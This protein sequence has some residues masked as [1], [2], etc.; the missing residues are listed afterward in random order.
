MNLGEDR[1]DEARPGRIFLEQPPDEEPSEALVIQAHDRAGPVG[2]L[3][4]PPTPT[5][6]GSGSVCNAPHAWSGIGIRGRTA[7][8]K[9]DD[10]G[11]RIAAAPKEFRRH[12][13][14]TAMRSVVSS[15]AM[16]IRTIV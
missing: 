5:T 3:F 4:P 15:L 1:G 8:A 2:D 6:S 13:A 9:H 11:A 7:A 14:E 12:D 16:W 10:T